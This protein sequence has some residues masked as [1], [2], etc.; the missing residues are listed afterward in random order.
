MVTTLAVLCLCAS[1]GSAEE[2]TETGSKEGAAKSAAAD[3]DGASLDEADANTPAALMAGHSMYGEAF[4]E[5]PRQKAY[6][7]G[8]TGQVHIEVT[9]SS[10]AAQKFVDQGIGQLHGF[11]WFEAER[12]FRQAA[13]LDPDCAMAYWGMGMANFSNASR[14]KGFIA[15]A[16]DL[17][18]R[19]SRREQMWI[20]ALNNYATSK[21]E[22][23]QKRADWIRNLEDIVLEFP[24]ELEAK[25]FSI[26]AQWDSNG[27]LPIVSHEA[28]NALI[29]DV[30]QVQPMHP[31]HHYRIH[32]WD[33]RKPARALASSALCGQG[34]PSIAHMWH[35]PGHIYWKVQR[36][37]DSAWQ[38]EASARVDHAHMVRDRVMPYQIHNYAHN[39][40]WLTRSLSHVGR[41][42]DAID[43]AKNMIELP[44]HPKKNDP[45]NRG[46]GAYYGRTR[47][48]EVLTRYEMWD[49]LIALADTMY[50]DPGSDQ[51]EQI[52]R[53]RS[54]GAAYF[55]K[56][57]IERGRQQHTALET[58]QGDLKDAQKKAGQEAE[59]KARDEVQKA[60][61]EKPDE[62][63]DEKKTAEKIAKAKK[64]AEKEFDSK[65]KAIETALDDL[66]ARL[67][68]ANGDAQKAMS[69]FE[70]VKDLSKEQLSQLHLQAGNK[71]KAEELAKQA[72]DASKNQVQPLANYADILHRVG[73]A[74]EATETFQKLRELSAPIDPHLPVMERLAPIVKELGLD[75]DWRAP[76]ASAN[77]VGE[78]PD[79]N[80]LGPFRWHPS[81]APSF[82]LA[83]A[84][85]RKLALK[86]F[87]G[88]PVVL[89]FYLGHGCLHCVEQLKKFAP[90]AEQYAEAGITLLAVSIETP[91]DLAL[92]LTNFNESGEFP[93]TLL[94]DHGLD[95]FK[96]YRA[97]DD[98]EERALHG[99]F[100]IDASGMVRWQDISFEPFSDAEFLLGESKRLLSQPAP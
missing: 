25:A 37:A 65:L 67:L 30:L 78:R 32:L 73:K 59:A 76:A 18:K 16:V 48:Y 96:A 53:L 87:Q 4:N 55:G 1:L 23:K 71:H 11:W 52:R 60:A 97:Y 94:S 81:P 69:Q 72:V 98:F 13:D 79:L 56:S 90:L 2:K 84:A 35:M 27:S 49:E 3:N 85:G 28:V 21:K 95:T 44:R 34:A 91:E 15:K 14:L 5:G 38:Q 80:K 58:M 42:R 70:K 41:V 9:T 92:S 20:D 99:T 17:K 63:Q 45:K 36:Y 50:L 74:K 8:G 19:V 12:S 89:I 61:Q 46:S 93:I 26:W 82:E 22:N 88:R 24:D 10:P 47:L 7:M 62:K 66:G 75:G 100:L 83:D 6:L 39:N 29:G 68:L 77:D 51:V 54:L 33:G 40:E 64:D 86:E 57:D 31:V 43:L